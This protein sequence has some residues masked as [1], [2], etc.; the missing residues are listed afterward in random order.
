MSKK[1]IIPIKEVPPQRN[2]ITSRDWVKYFLEVPSGHALEETKIPYSTLRVALNRLIARKAIPN[3]FE[4]RSRKIDGV[5]HIY[6]IHH[7]RNPSK[8][9]R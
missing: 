3:E 5:M 9:D 2:K 7:T 4:L 8:N 6:I 1:R